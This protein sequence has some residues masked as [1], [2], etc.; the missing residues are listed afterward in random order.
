[1]RTHPVLLGTGKTATLSLLSFSFSNGRCHK[2]CISAGFGERNG[3]AFDGKKGHVSGWQCS[4][5]TSC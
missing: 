2:A 5:E 1:M 4:V 3:L